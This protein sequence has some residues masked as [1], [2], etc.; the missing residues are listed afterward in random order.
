MTT[1]PYNVSISS[2]K[3]DPTTD[4]TREVNCGQ[5]TKYPAGRRKLVYRFMRKNGLSPSHAARLRDVR[6]TKL[7]TCR[8]LTTSQVKKL[9]KEGYR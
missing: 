1:S 5:F 2:R 8:L 9:N 3:N 4:W 7:V 6:T